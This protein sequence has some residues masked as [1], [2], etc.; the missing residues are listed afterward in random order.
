MKIKS[1]LKLINDCKLYIEIKDKK[2]GASY[3]FFTKND[4]IYNSKYNNYSIK[5]INSQY[6]QGKRLLVLEIDY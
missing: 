1:I 5:A 2:T 3:G 6:F 4:L